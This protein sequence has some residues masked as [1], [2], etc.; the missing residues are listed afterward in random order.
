M[1]P[2]ECL[3]D[4]CKSK[5][6]E[7]PDIPVA[8]I[9]MKVSCAMCHSIIGTWTC[10]QP[11]SRGIITMKYKKGCRRGRSFNLSFDE[12]KNLKNKIIQED[13]KSKPLKNKMIFIGST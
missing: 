8:C 2:Y 7:F 9:T 13:N 6:I 11:Y 1:S 12:I 10:I 4:K 3:N 5:C